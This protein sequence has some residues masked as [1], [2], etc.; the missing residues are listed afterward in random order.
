MLNFPTKTLA[1]APRQR[2]IGRASDLLDIRGHDA[3]DVGAVEL[4]PTHPQRQGAAPPATPKRCRTRVPPIPLL[5]VPPDAA[6]D[7]LPSD[8]PSKVV[9]LKRAH[10]TRTSPGRDGDGSRRDVA[11]VTIVRA[12]QPANDG[13]ERRAAILA[14]VDDL[15][16]LAAELYFSGRLPREDPA[17]VTNTADKKS[18]DDV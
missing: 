11:R 6:R 14:L 15:A 4:D 10:T 17:S 3:H 2:H 7:N 5:L 8:L 13:P 9:V 16:A 18:R 12:S 1:A